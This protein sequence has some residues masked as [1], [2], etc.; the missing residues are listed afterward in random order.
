MQSLL[1]SSF[2]SIHTYSPK[3]LQ[4]SD[5]ERPLRLLHTP[6]RPVSRGTVIPSR[7]TVALQYTF[8]DNILLDNLILKAVNNVDDMTSSLAS[9]Y[10]AIWNS[11]TWA[12]SDRWG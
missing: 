1:S 2:C 4:T 9:L 8:G 10:A 3:W 5:I 7:I 11:R 6:P 12:E